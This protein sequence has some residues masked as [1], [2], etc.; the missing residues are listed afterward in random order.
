MKVKSMI[1]KTINQNKIPTLQMMESFTTQYIESHPKQFISRIQQSAN[2]HH[3][4]LIKSKA[5]YGQIA[6]ASPD[7]IFKQTMARYQEELTKLSTLAN[8]ALQFTP[9][10]DL[11][12]PVFRF[13]GLKTVEPENNLFQPISRK[14]LKSL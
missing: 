13:L 8:K 7:Q 14:Y 11:E 1:P 3:T 9:P 2:N 6:G 5:M 10:D 4:Q 12:T